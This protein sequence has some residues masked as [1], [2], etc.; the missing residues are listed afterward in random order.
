VDDNARFRATILGEL[1]LLHTDVGNYRIALGYLLDRDKLPSMDNTEGLDVLVSKAEALLHVGREREAATAAEAAVAMIGRNPA[2]RPY[3]L[4]ALDWAA[5][6]NL[7]S[8]SFPRALTLY[9]AEIPLLDGAKTPLAERNRIVAH[10]SRAAAALGAGQPA[11]ALNDL[12]YVDAQ[13]GDGRDAKVAE[14]LR[15]PHAT[16][17]H[18]VRAYRM[19]AAGLRA[20]ANRALGRLDAEAQAIETRRAILEERFGETVRVELEQEQMLTETQLATNASERHDV[21]ATGQWLGK[22]LAHAD[23]LRARANGVTDRAQLDVL[24]L[25]AALTVSMGATLVA[26]L[27]KRFDSAAV[28]MAQRRDPSLRTYQRWFEIYGALVG[29]P[30][31]IPPATADK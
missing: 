22:A 28:E 23:D 2:L 31:A 20:R 19:M 26:D 7:A 29:P 10:I 27:P 15:W 12:D 16:A 13:I 30:P 3:Q 24:W 5:V 14:V 6:D 11:R 18:V 4:L 9:D 17:E 21:A 25:A 1:G 8:G